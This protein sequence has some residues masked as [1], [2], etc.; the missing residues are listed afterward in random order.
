MKKVLV[1][2]TLSAI[3][4]S[5]CESTD[6]SLNKELDNNASIHNAAN[7][8]AEGNA[9]DAQEYFSGL[10][11]E[12][13]AVDI[14]YREMEELDIMNASEEEINASIDSCLILVNMGRK[15]LK[16]YEDKTW[17]KRKD[18]HNITLEWFDG[19]EKMVKQYAKPL[20]GAMSLP[21]EEWTDENYELYDEWQ[22]AY[23]E[24]L[25]LDARWVDYQ[26]E[27]AKANGFSLA[28]ETIDVDALV[29]EELGREE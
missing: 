7:S 6:N 23:D 21:D 3:V 2:L 4:L 28:T 19:I 10:L 17:A 27:F 12:V 15:A 5:S 14:K 26:H 20:A 11:A 16:K 8:F 1:F 25:D 24:F 9:K 29:D 18:F 22:D 13:I